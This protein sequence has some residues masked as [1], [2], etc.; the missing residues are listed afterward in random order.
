MKDQRKIRRVGCDDP[1]FQLLVSRLDQELWNELKEDQGTYDQFNRV[2]GI[3]TAVIVYVG[4]VPAAIG[5]F[6]EFNKDTVEI[7]RMFVEKE[8]RGQGLSKNVLNELEKWAIELGYHHAVLETSVHFEPA[9]KLYAGAGYKIIE[10]YDQYKGLTESVCMKKELQPHVAERGKETGNQEAHEKSSFV[11]RNDIEY[12]V[13]EEDFVEGNIRCIPMIVRF[14]M[15]MAGI[16]LKLK[17]WNKFSE[18]E[19]VTLATMPCDGAQETKD[20]Y[21]YLDRLIR[22]RTGNPSTRMAV[23]QQPEWD[24]LFTVPFAIAEKMSGVGSA[25]SLQQWKSLTQLQRFALMK[26][27]RPGH[28]SKNFM[29]AAKEFGLMSRDHNIGTGIISR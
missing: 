12:F 1:G 25:I 11:K 22:D 4:K 19:R 28:E 16:K 5:C 26:L 24:N 18:A 2:K 29:L 8:F 20:Y 14:K 23:D 10:N 21:E 27:S 3:Q 7:K 13:F 17:E 15:D 6:K 9:R